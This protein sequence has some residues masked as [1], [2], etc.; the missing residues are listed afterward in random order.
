MHEKLTW[1]SADPRYAQMLVLRT[2][3]EELK[4][5]EYSATELASYGPR[6]KMSPGETNGI[7][8]PSTWSTVAD[9]EV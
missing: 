8:D 2:E 6:R 9:T 7:K 3:I 1:N 4:G 5:H